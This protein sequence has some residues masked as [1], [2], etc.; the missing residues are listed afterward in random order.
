MYSVANIDSALWGT[1]SV[2]NVNAT[3]KALD[4]TPPPPFAEP[5]SSQGLSQRHRRRRGRPVIAPVALVPGGCNSSGDSCPSQED[6]D[7]EDIEVLSPP[8]SH[9]SSRGRGGRGRRRLGVEPEAMRMPMGDV[10]RAMEG[11][12]LRDVELEAEELSEEPRARIAEPQRWERYR[13]AVTPL[14][15]TGHRDSDTDC[16]SM[17]GA[18]ANSPHDAPP[19]LPPPSSSPGFPPRYRWNRYK[20]AVAPAVAERE[21]DG[22]EERGVASGLDVNGREMVARSGAVDALPRPSR[23]RTRPRY[24]HHL[25]PRNVAPLATISGADEEKGVPWNSRANRREIEEPSL[26]PRAPTIAKR[27]RR[28]CG[29]SL[30][31]RKLIVLAVWVLVNMGVTVVFLLWRL[32]LVVVLNFFSNFAGL[33]TIVVAARVEA[34]LQRRSSHPP[35][36]SNGSSNCGPTRQCSKK[37]QA[38]PAKT[39]DSS[40]LTTIVS[41][42]AS[43]TEMV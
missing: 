20:L 5:P 18:G 14:S 12:V 42:W 9:T 32:Y 23:R 31:K 25:G 28:C 41:K 8:R 34:F 10:R 26:P 13:L 33:V 43:S 40:S 19:P 15:R 39:S 17:H 11:G 3:A 27:R 7:D 4:S 2:G 37:R 35:N 24:G 22:I 36:A 16:E 21:R 1:R 29:L 30:R 38:G 6:D